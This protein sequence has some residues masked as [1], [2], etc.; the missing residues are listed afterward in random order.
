MF[1]W[2]T[3]RL[4]GKGA[5]LTRLEKLGSF[6]AAGLLN[7]AVF[8]FHFR[9]AGYYLALLLI[10]VVYEFVISIKDRTFSRKIVNVVLIGI[11]SLLLISPVLIPSFQSYLERAQT[12]TE[13]VVAQE[14]SL[15]EQDYFGYTFDTIYSIGARKWMVWLVAAATVINFFIFPKWAFR[16]PHLDGDL[17]G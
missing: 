7:A 11:L 15:A 14:T 4:V 6:I 3:I 16:N 9:V 2:E 8:L 17:M 12:K 13:V 10:S 5:D 1:I